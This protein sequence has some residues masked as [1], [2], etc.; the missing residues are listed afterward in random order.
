MDVALL[1]NLIS[2]GKQ[3]HC[4]PS[5]STY[6]TI[7]LNLAIFDVRFKCKAADSA[8]FEYSQAS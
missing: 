6:I 1:F 3:L 8:G 7:V 4:G 5:T 2:T